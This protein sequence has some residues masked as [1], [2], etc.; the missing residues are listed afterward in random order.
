MEFETSTASIAPAAGGGA[1]TS[2]VVE[3]RAPNRRAT[4]HAQFGAK[5]LETGE[6]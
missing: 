6:R 2:C 4:L 5:A 1:E 3:A